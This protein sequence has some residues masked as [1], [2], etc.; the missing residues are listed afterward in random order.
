MSRRSAIFVIALLAAMPVG[1]EV[2]HYSAGWR[3]FDAGRAV[4]EV[5]PRESLVHV[6]THGVVG[7]L[8]PVDDRYHATFNESLCAINSL[9]HAV[10]ADEQSETAVTFEPGIARRVETDLKLHEK[11]T[12]EVATPACVHED[13]GVAVEAGR[14]DDAAV[15]RREEV[16]AGARGGGWCGGDQDAGGAVS[17]HAV[18][19]VP[20]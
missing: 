1:A 17:S 13:S 11:K 20:L 7:K 10:E 5:R 15:E 18:R 3:L 16:R 6:T 19:G 8:H 12:A 4:I 9:M 14:R 2:F